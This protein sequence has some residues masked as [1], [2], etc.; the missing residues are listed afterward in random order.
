MAAITAELKLLMA[1]HHHH[2]L[3]LAQSRGPDVSPEA[4]RFLYDENE[5]VRHARVQLGRHTL[6]EQPVPLA[7]LLGQIEGLIALQ[8]LRL[9]ADG[10]RQQVRLVPHHYRHNISVLAAP[11]LFVQLLQLYD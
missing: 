3:L 5:A 10:G 11:H 1:L 4:Q 8:S 7:K 2:L 6:V 9:G